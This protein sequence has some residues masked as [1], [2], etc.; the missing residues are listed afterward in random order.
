LPQI[1]AVAVIG[2]PDERWGETGR[3]IVVPAAGAEISLDDLTA[4]LDGRVGRFK[5]PRSM[6]IVPEL[7][8]TA[9]GK[10]LKTELR[11]LY[12]QPG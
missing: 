4:H 3:A 12:G 8:V 2:I 6:V 11:R 1:A 7:P 9:T 5:V 10:I